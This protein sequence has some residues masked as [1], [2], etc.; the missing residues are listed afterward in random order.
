MSIDFDCPKS[1][2]NVV[3]N[4]TLS[5]SFVVKKLKNFNDI[6]SIFTCRNFQNN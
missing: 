3:L 6:V 1:H 2:W 5:D 4:C